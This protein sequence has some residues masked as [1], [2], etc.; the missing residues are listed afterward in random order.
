MEKVLAYVAANQDRYLSQLFELLRIESVSADPAREG[1]VRR[2]GQWVADFL[3]QAGFARV[4]VMETGGH[5]AVY[6]EWLGAPGAPTVLVYGHYDVQPEDPRD[7]WTVRPF[8]PVVKDGN[9]WGRGTSDDKAQFMTHLFAMEA[10]LKVEGRLPCNVKVFIEGEEEGGKGGTHD[11]VR[12]HTDLLACDAVAVSDTAWHA[13]DLPTIVYALR[14]IA[15]FQVDVKGPDRDLHSGVYGGIVHNPLNAIGRIIA[16]MQ[17]AA[18]RITAPGFYDDVVPLSDAEKAEF[19]KVAPPDAETCADL[20]VGGLWGEAG[21]TAT[22]R[23]WG[24]PSFDV[25][26]IWGGFTGAGSKTVIAS[27]GGFKFSCRL[28]A[29]QDPAKIGALL[30]QYLPT[31]VPAGVTVKVTYLHGGTPVM[32]TTD[33]PFLAAAQDAVQTAF[34]TRPVLVREGAS[35]PITAVF[36][37]SLKAPAILVGYGLNSDNIHSP[38]EKFPLEHFRKGIAC[39]VHLY[40]RFAQVGR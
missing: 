26:G 34:G 39:G 12:A 13:P 20:H 28:V 30:E 18:G 7:K 35:I 24:R 31:L 2:A 38:D 23:N 4:E 14:G 10:W 21:Y 3:A 15:Y 1:E 33:S 16:G 9:I 29:N 36:L 6:G 19:A 22:E 25:H 11:F 5:P 37:E 17:D 32:V 40:D 27:E 8:D